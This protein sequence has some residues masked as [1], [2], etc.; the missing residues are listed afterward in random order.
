MIRGI[1]FDVLIWLL[2]S[3]GLVAFWH[4]SGVEKISLGKAGLYGLFTAII[5]G[6]L[7]FI[8]VSLF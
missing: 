3:L 8:M 2:V 7:I 1:M 6:I 4:L 5:S